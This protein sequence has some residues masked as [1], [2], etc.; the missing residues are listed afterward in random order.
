METDEPPGRARGIGVNVPH[1][2]G[3]R[4]TIDE[5]KRLR[6]EKK[7][8]KRQQIATLVRMDLMKE[9]S[10]HAQNLLSQEVN[11]PDSEI[12]T[13]TPHK[14]SCASADPTL[15]DYDA[16]IFDLYGMTRKLTCE[17]RMHKRVLRCALV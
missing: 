7:A 3:F 11:M 1:N 15:I 5:K 14:S 4:L 12:I 13:T 2:R 17:L 8:L 6:E 16:P 10:V 9:L